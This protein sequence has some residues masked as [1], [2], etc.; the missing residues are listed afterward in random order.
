MVE[1]E[2]ERYTPEHQK[3]RRGPRGIRI[4]SSEVPTIC[5]LTK[6]A[7]PVSLWEYL[8]VIGE[9]EGGRE[10]TQMM[11]H[12]RT[13]EEYSANLY[14]TLT[15]WEVAPGNY[16][17]PDDPIY[18]DLFGCSPARKVLAVEEEK[19]EGG[20]QVDEEN[21]KKKKATKAWE[22]ILDIHNPCYSLGTPGVTADKMAKIQYQL[23]ITKKQWCDYLVTLFDFEDAKPDKLMGVRMTRVYYIKKYWEE[24]LLPQL[25]EFSECL[26][27]KIRPIPLSE[28][29]K[30]SPPPLVHTVDYAFE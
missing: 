11:R 26:E 19:G 9:E 28:R 18:S 27:K 4:G 13:C 15:G 7:S 10:D 25:L 22:G 16:H 6:Y 12:G 30:R 21:G 5:G 8:V 2:V 20:M 24:W 1:I 17:Y 14:T 23:F 3:L 29:P